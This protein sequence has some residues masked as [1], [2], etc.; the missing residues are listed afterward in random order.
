MSAALQEQTEVVNPR[1]GQPADWVVAWRIIQGIPLG[2]QPTRA[3]IRLAVWYL[4]DRGLKV[5]PI[6]VRTGLTEREVDTVAELRRRSRWS[7]T[8]GPKVRRQRA[9]QARAARPHWQHLTML[10]AV[11]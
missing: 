7:T 3:E 5:P 10:G 1:E 11:R 8:Q 6:I 2:C 4:L 9:R